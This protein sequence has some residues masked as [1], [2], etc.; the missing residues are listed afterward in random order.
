MNSKNIVAIHQPNY[1]PWLGYFY[2]MAHCDIFVYLDTVQYPRGQSFASRN[3]IKTPN[4][5]SYLSVPVNIPKGRNGKVS[6]S[7]VEFANSMWQDK[8]LKTLEMNYKRAPFFEDVMTILTHQIRN[9]QNLVEL[10]IGLIEAIATYMNIKTE[11]IRLSSILPKFRQKTELIID[12]CRVLDA[13]IYLSG[14]GGG[15]EYNDETLLNKE[16]IQLHYSS[17]VHPEYRQLWGDFVSHLSI[18]DLL[19]NHG[20]NSKKKLLG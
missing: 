7:E 11:R 4:G 18:I 2:K 16:N 19:F 10:N 3:R 9:T 20:P 6:Y 12:I 14:D 15:R 1:L 13:Y 8:H 5:W 17:F